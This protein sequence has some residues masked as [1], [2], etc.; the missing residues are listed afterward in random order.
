MNELIS[1]KFLIIVSIFLSTL[2]LFNQASAEVLIGVVDIQRIIAESKIGIEARKRV[3]AEMKRDEEKLKGME[4]EVKGMQ[5]SLG[6]QS[7]ILSGQALE[8]KKDL[9]TKKERELNLLLQE[10]KESVMRKN[11]NEIGKLV[12]QIDKVVKTVAGKKNL[13]FVFEKDPYFVIY[14]SDQTDI[15][16]QVL[17]QL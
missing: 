12:D 4:Q 1:K 6:K 5:E 7:S 11:K 3:E 15:T 2:C 10:H 13:K 14:N 16:D 8:E 17:E 9:I